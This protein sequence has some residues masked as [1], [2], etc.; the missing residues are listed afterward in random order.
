MN[1]IVMKSNITNWNDLHL[2]NPTFF[3]FFLFKQDEVSETVLTMNNWL[4]APQF[5][6]RWDRN[7]EIPSTGQ[8]IRQWGTW[9]ASTKDMKTKPAPFGNF[10][11]PDYSDTLTFI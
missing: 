7:K 2:I 3:I 8:W 11:R 1:D 4:N 6:G 9:K 5:I 10:T